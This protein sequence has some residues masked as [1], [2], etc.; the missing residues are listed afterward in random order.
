MRKNVLHI[1]WAVRLIRRW[2]ISQKTKI[3]RKGE[4]YAEWVLNPAGT[5]LQLSEFQ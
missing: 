3:H 1:Y 2:N 5:A 4:N